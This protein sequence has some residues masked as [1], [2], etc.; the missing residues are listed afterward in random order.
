MAGH[1]GTRIVAVLLSGLLLALGMFGCEYTDAGDPQRAAAPTRSSQPR[2]P[3]PTKD[4]ATLTLEANNLVA[5]KELLGQGSGAVILE[6]SGTVGGAVSG[7]NKSARVEDAGPYTVTAACIGAPE[8][9][10][11]IAQD[12]LTGL[13]PQD[14]TFDCSAP[15]A[16][17]VQLQPGP[18]TVQVQVVRANS[19]NSTS[20]GAGEVAA[21]RIAANG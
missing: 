8:V 11:V 10:L 19:G 2:A 17:V 16:R 15:Y 7:V 5:A 12:P 9:H 3:L 18:V 21:V 6:D 13:A 1:G 14:E 20:A 4:P